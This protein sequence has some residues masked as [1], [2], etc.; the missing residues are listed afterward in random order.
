VIETITMFTAL[1]RRNPLATRIVKMTTTA[2]AG[3][4]TESG[5]APNMFMV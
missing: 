4:R 5:D 3:Q 2:A 1:L